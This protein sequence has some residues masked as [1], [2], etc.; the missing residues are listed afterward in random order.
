MAP[1]FNNAGQHWNH[2][3]FWQ[4]M[5]PTE[6]GKMP[7]ALEKKIDRGSRRRRTS[8]R[9]TF[10]AGGHRPVRLGLG[11]AGSWAPTAS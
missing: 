5:S 9:P 7:A 10:K 11:L 6:G 4:N 8:S 1:V 3:L 2:N